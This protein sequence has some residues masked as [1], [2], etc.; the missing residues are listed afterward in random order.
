MTTLYPC[1]LKVLGKT[2]GG[3]EIRCM[4]AAGHLNECDPIVR[5]RVACKVC[6]GSGAA[7]PATTI[8]AITCVACRGEGWVRE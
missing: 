4:R 7:R 1:C 2:K 3:K 6:G 8:A 5:E